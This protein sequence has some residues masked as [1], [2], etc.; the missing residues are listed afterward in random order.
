MS[1]GT[2][3]H[4]LSVVAVAMLSALVVFIVVFNVSRV[5]RNYYEARAECEDRCWPD[6]PVISYVRSPVTDMFECYCDERYRAP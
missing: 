2:I 4:R 5:T 1:T 6:K 3:K